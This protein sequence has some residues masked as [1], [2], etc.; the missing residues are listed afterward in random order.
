LE[1]EFGYRDSI[2][3]NKL[4]GQYFI[5][6]ITVKL[7]KINN[8][9]TTYKVLREYLEKNNIEVKSSKDISNAV[10][11]IRRS[12]LPDPKVVGNAGSFFKNVFLEKEKLA[13]FL[14]KYPDAPYFEEDD[15]IKI[16]AGWLI[17]QCGWKGKSI[18][19]VGVYDKQ[20]LVLVNHGGATGA[21]IK[22]LAFQIIKCV[23]DKFDLR[24]NPEVNLM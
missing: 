6:A 16:P 21:E 3:K 19:H 1:C 10:I 7:S 5:T 20:S 17:E 8:K 4:K 2:F 24:L 11:N 23:Q 18:G 22:D 14:E 12:K 15:L 9:N 13:N